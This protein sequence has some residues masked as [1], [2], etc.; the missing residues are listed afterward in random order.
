MFWPKAVMSLCESLSDNRNAQY[1]RIMAMKWSK[2]A[3]S[4]TLCNDSKL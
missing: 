3:T 1:G 4:L 2:T